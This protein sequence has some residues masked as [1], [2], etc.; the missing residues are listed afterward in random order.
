MLPTHWRFEI[1]A[2]LKSVLAA[3][4]VFAIAFIVWFVVVVLPSGMGRL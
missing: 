3:V 4:G 2:A 1:G